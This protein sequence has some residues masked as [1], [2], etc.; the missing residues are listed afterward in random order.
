MGIKG[1]EKGRSIVWE[2]GNKVFSSC[3]EAD[4]YFGWPLGTV[5]HILRGKQLPRSGYTI[6]DASVPPVSHSGDVMDRIAAEM[7]GAPETWKPIPGYEEVYSMSNYGH[8][9]SEKFP[10][11]PYKK[12]TRTSVGQQVVV[13]NKDNIRRMFTIRALYNLTWY[14]IPVPKGRMD[15][16]KRGKRVRCTTDGREF[17]TYAD[18]ARFYHIDYG[19]FQRI[20]K[21]QDAEPDLDFEKI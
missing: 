13:L 18:C 6:K 2:E 7:N 15:Y 21:K 10:N 14:G 5:S 17:D 8:I 3:R 16:A 12:I 4:V 11:R 19:K 20:L 9:R 1:R